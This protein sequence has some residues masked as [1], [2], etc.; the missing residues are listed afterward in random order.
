MTLVINYSNANNFEREYYK[1]RTG[2]RTGIK[3]KI[4]LYNPTIQ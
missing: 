3:I 2:I 1:T 4:L